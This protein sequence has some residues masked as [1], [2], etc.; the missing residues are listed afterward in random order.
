MNLF[1]WWSL[2]DTTRDP[3]WLSASCMTVE[4][5]EFEWRDQREYSSKWVDENKSWHESEEFESVFTEN[6]H[7]YLYKLWKPVMPVPRLLQKLHCHLELKPRRPQSLAAKTG[8]RAALKEKFAKTSCCIRSS[9]Q[10][11][12]FSCNSHFVSL[13]FIFIFLACFPTLSVLLR[14]TATSRLYTL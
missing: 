4:G 13:P 2:R 12:V 14:Q 5:V 10:A 7:E 1:C 3:R 8:R 9:W 6:D 11:W